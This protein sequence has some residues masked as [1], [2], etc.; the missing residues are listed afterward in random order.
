M[1]PFASRQ[2]KM[3]TI[4]NSSP[5]MS[6]ASFIAGLSVSLFTLVSFIRGVSLLRPA[7][8]GRRSQHFPTTARGES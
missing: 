3:W 1:T 4:A 8:D 2:S 5:L 7:F 6:L